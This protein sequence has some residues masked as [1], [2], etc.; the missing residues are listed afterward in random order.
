MVSDSSGGCKVLLDVVIG[1]STTPQVSFVDGPPNHK[2]LL[3]TGFREV[4]RYAI[5]R[6]LCRFGSRSVPVG[7]KGL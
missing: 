3:L 5:M 2:I 6:R 7:L 4:D 1:S